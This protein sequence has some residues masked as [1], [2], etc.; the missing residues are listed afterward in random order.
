MEVSQLGVFKLPETLP[1][2]LDSFRFLGG[3]VKEG[4]YLLFSETFILGEDESKNFFGLGRTKT[5]D[6]YVRIY[7]ED[8]T[9]GFN[10]TCTD[11]E[12]SKI[13]TKTAAATSFMEAHPTQGHDCQIALYHFSSQAHA[14]RQYL[15][16][17]VRITVMVADSTFVK[18]KYQDFHVEGLSTCPTNQWPLALAKNTEVN[19][20][21]DEQSYYNY[22]LVRYPVKATTNSI[23]PFEMNSYYFRFNETQRF[24]FELGSNF[25]TA[26]ATMKLMPT[27]KSFGYFEI[28]G[29]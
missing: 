27:Q 17:K 3:G 12:T 25:V 22:P 14:A 16:E 11:P 24:Y 26:H 5:N 4:D 18:E 21:S 23:Y 9:L 20:D 19:T 1:L 7:L 28:Q 29:K 13:T 6:T 2:S 15:N 8:E 10:F